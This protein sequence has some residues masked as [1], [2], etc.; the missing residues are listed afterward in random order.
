MG[1]TP[2]RHVNK[3]LVAS[4]LVFSSLANA[5]VDRNAMVQGTLKSIDDKIAVVQTEGGPVRIP[6]AAVK[7]LNFRPGQAVLVPVDIAD[8]LDLNK[9][10]IAKLGRKKT[11]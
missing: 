8:L 2:L 7:A 6:A 1:D 10:T 3:L 11:E 9:D 4:V 5:Y